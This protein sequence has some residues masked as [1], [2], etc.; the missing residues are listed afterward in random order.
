VSTPTDQT[1][2]FNANGSQSWAQPGGVI[3]LVEGASFCLSAP[4]GD[5]VPDHAQGLFVRDARYL[6]RWELQ[7][8]GQPV[9]PLSIQP[10]DPF[11]ALLVGRPHPRRGEPE[12]TLLVIRRRLVADGLREDLTLRNLSATA[13]EVTVT[14][15]AEA[16]FANLFAV[17]DGRVPP[18]GPQRV[19]TDGGQLGI[20]PAGWPDGTGALVRSDCGDPVVA[21][22][23]LTFRA[24]VPARGEWHVCLEVLAARPGEALPSPAEC[25]EPVTASVAAQRLSAWREG[26][27][28]IRTEHAALAAALERTEADLGSLRIFDPDRPEL[29]AVAAGAPWYMTLFGRDSLLTSWMALLVDPQL[30]IGT[31]HYLSELQG[32]VVDP[33]SEE[34]PGRILHEMRHGSGL[35]TTRRAGDSL[36]YGTADATPLF[37]LLL[38]ELYRWGFADDA[39]PLLPAAD[40]ALA[41]ITDYGDR[42]GDGFVE[43]RRATDAGLANQGWK[44]SWD[45]VAFGDGRFAETPIALCEVQAYVYGAYRAR[46]DIARVERDAPTAA[47]YDKRAEEL[48]QAF[49][50]RFWLPDPGY[51]AFALDA[52]KQRVDAMTSNMG[53][54]LWTGILDQDKADQVADHLVSPELF[55]GWG[56]RTLARSAARYN[57]VSYH[58]GS[59]WPH[60]TAIAVAGLARYG[61]T[62][63][64]QRI[65]TGLLDAADAFDGR[66]P[67]LFC[68]FDRAEFAAPVPYPSSC[69]PQAWAAAAPLLLVRSLLGL[70]PAVPAGELRVAPAL[71]PRMGELRVQ[72][73]PLAGGRVSVTA[74]GYRSEVTGLPAGLRLRTT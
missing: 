42:D 52:G 1:G 56:V 46:A 59:V 41:W 51:L 47:E 68:G 19:S 53:H 21:P 7:L 26:A 33:A 20:W 72:G 70:S 24:V 5:I 63:E 9:E 32:R 45:A 74:H 4:S 62:A 37:V 13:A 43:Y 18:A 64:A 10:T 55:T 57:P 17:K 22:G 15:L 60:D 3:T 67:E 16:D 28:R 25:R 61:R 66:L 8:D 2:P 39:R 69:S 6:S 49:N 14:V 35:G 50:E 36:Y 38:G 40:R 48:K 11:A 34:E 30:A 44:D 71:S 23:S 27:P 12:G 58:N 29:P 54:C 65:A 73:L 31:L